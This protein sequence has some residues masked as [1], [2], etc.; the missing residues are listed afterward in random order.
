MSSFTLDDLAAATDAEYAHT[1][2]TFTDTDDAGKAEEVTVVFRNALQLSREKR[3]QMEELQSDEDE[4]TEDEGEVEQR[5]IDVLMI[6][7]DDPR[8]AERL[9]AQIGENL[10]MIVQLF[11][12]YN[13]QTQLGEASTSQS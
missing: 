1:T 13:G 3:K 12:Q 11:K 5:F 9:F 6:A 7:A 10:G 4:G 8:A 2:I